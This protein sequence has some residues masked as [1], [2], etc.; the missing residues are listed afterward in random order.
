VQEL[1]N[2]FRIIV[3]GHGHI[4]SHVVHNHRELLE[5]SVYGLARE[6]SEVLL[7]S[8]VSRKQVSL[9]LIVPSV[10]YS[11]LMSYRTSQV[12]LTNPIEFRL[13]KGTK[14][15]IDHLVVGVLHVP[16]SW[17][18][19]LYGMNLGTVFRH[20]PKQ[21]SLAAKKGRHPSLPHLVVLPE[22]Q[23]RPSGQWMTAPQ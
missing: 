16:R 19:E 13:A 20:I 4:G 9:N 18:K 14:Q 5:H 6:M 8:L 17:G 2:P 15:V 12:L 21:L 1:H 11:Q 22:D 3:W 7:L 10:S 23:E